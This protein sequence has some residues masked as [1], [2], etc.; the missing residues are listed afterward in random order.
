MA[1]YLNAPST[2]TTARLIAGLEI[3][4]QQ[5]AVGLA[6]EHKRILQEEIESQNEQVKLLNEQLNVA[7]KVFDFSGYD[8]DALQH[9]I[10]LAQ[11]D[12]EKKAVRFFARRGL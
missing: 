1:Q 3:M 8:T 12:W 2:L 11:N 4:T 6:E 10:D 5:A 7:R 9:D